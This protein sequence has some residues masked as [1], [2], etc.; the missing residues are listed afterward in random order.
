MSKKKDIER[1][2][3]LIS[4]WLF[5]I[6]LNNCIDLFDINKIAEDLA[7]MLLNEIYNYNLINLNYQKHHHSAIDLGDKKN[8]IA[9]QVTSRTD[10]DKIKKNLKT[11]VE[12]YKKDY[13][14]GIRFFLLSIEG[15]KIKRLKN[16]KGLKR[17]APH[18]DPHEHILSEKEIIRGIERLY[19]GDRERF[20]KV[21]QI[22]EEEIAG[23][24]MKAYNRRG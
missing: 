9:F 20:N 1:V 5:K 18:F 23:K 2:I 7:A 4:W 14:N 24:A 19:T 13:P 15:A 22:L 11:F 21:K 17:I 3:H 16:Q 10:A 8:G 12:K 6:K